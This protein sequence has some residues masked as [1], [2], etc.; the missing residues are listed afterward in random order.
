MSSSARSTPPT[1]TAPEVGAMK[2]ISTFKAVDLPL[3]ERPT[4]ASTSPGRMVQ[5]RSSSEARS[6][7]G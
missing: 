4:K 7:P 3:P 2:P 5:L 6:A 1:R